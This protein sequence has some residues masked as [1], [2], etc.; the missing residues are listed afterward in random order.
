MAD[1]TSLSSA[2]VRCRRLH[3]RRAPAAGFGSASIPAP[4]KPSTAARTGPPSSTGSRHA[5]PAA[6]DCRSRLRADSAAA[7]A[8]SRSRH[9]LPVEAGC[10]P[11]RASM[12]ASS[13]V[14]A[15][16]LVTTP[17]TM[18]Y[19]REEGVDTL[20]LSSSADGFSAAAVVVRRS[21]SAG[22]YVMDE[23]QPWRVSVDPRV[24]RGVSAAL[25]KSGRCSEWL[26]ERR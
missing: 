18:R 19:A 9:V 15:G 5:L 13:V 3:A 7:T 4:A 1:T 6:G 8:G 21:V 14:R 2:A 24:I 16:P 17:E 10:G 20:A 22:A 26:R 11:G 25:P 12:A 23:E